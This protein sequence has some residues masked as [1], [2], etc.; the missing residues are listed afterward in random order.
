MWLKQR[1]RLPLE[2]RRKMMMQ[3]VQIMNRGTEPDDEGTRD[4]AP[5]VLEVDVTLRD[6][7]LRLWSIAFSI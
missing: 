1:L 5:V 2:M 3:W 4:L 7:V 6:V